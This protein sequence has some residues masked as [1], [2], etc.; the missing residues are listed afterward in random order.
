MKNLRTLKG[1]NGFTILEVL[2]AALITAIIVA[3]AFSFYTKMHLQ[4]EAQFDVSEM[5]QLCRTSLYD[6]RK[7]LIQ[8]GFKIGA[9]PP[10]EIKG[11]TL[12]V[13]YS[14]TKPVDTIKYYLQEFTS[15]EYNKIKNRPSGTKLYKLM[16][17]ENSAEAS[18]FADFIT[19]IRYTVVSPDEIN[20]G[21]TV[22]AP[23]KDDSY[24]ANSGFRL[25][26]ISDKI[27]VRNVQ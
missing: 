24:K 21:I 9:H 1:L 7:S 18:I 17:K 27:N 11:D 22:M 3:S 6:I 16:K 15:A 4:S 26:T 14:A 10:Y 5:Q 13:Y 2:I 12:A 23:H 8:G 20:V 19:G 25:Y